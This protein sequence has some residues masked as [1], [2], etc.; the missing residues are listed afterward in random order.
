MIAIKPEWHFWANG[1]GGYFEA[2][3]GCPLGTSECASYCICGCSEKDRKDPSGVGWQCEHLFGN[4]K[5]FRCKKM[6]PKEKKSSKLVYDKNTKTIKTEAGK[7][8]GL[9]ISDEEADVFG[10]KENA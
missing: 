9:T 5:D 6:K 3:E 7:H 2:P 1:E 4:D 10:E 8:T